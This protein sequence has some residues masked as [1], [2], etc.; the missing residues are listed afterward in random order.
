MVYD[1]K[2]DEHLLSIIVP[3]YNTEKYLNRCIDSIL[4][5]TH[6]HLELILID[7]G[8]TDN[9][10]EICC[11]MKKLDNRIRV[12]H[13]ENQGVVAA[14]FHGLVV[15]QGDYI[16]F[17]DSD[18]W[19]GPKKYCEYCLT[20]ME[21]NREVDICIPC[22]MRNFPDGSE[23]EMYREHSDWIMPRE[24]AAK[25][26]LRQEFFDWLIGSIFSRKVL[27]SWRPVL[28][29]R[30][31][32]DLEMMWNVIKYSNKV[33]YS[34]Q[35]IYHYRVV[36]SSASQVL[37]LECNTAPVFKRILANFW[38]DDAESRVL[39]LNEAMRDVVARIREY[40]F[41]SEHQFLDEI[42]SE[43]KTLL[44]FSSQYPEKKQIPEVVSI[45]SKDIAIYKDV[46]ACAFMS[47]ENCAKQTQSYINRYI[48][49]TGIIGS[50]FLRILEKLGLSA[51]AFAVSN[52][53]PCP[54]MHLGKP[55]FHIGDIPNQEGQTC[56]LIAV[57]RKHQKDVLNMLKKHGHKTYYLPDIKWIFWDNN[58][59]ITGNEV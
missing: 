21:E 26:M 46:F 6:K 23:V 54:M 25:E 31:A 3:V 35:S 32:E 47:M 8:S 14:R 4:E 39:L 45:L 16:G 28:G 24:T 36:G 13:Q 48:Y 42:H 12:F 50:Y 20:V 9:S 40:F 58:L 27:M 38:L 11:K 10:Y 17:V 18:D 5:Q 29:V 52:N 53:Q 43:Q 51:T 57:R 56:F 34:S 30:H 22:R 2:Q 19:I 7:D 44:Y 1:K 15:A 55:V 33:F 49:G 41:L 37:P 59:Q